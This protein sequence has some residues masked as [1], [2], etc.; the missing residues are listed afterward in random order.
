MQ[1]GKLLRF[2]YVD[3]LGATDDVDLVNGEALDLRIPA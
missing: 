2:E 3:D 1:D